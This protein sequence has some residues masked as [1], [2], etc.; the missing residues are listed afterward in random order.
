MLKIFNTLSKKKEVF[1]PINKNQVNIYVCGVTVYDFCHIGHGRTFITF[2]MI[3]RYLKC[4]GFNVK[5]VRNIT[6]IDDKIILKAL[7][8]KTD[9]NIFTDFMI[10]EMHKDFNALKIAI[11]DQEPRVTDYIDNIIN[12]I[13]ELIKNQH[14]YVNKYGDVLF[15]IKNCNDYGILSRQ[16]LHSLA[17]RSHVLSNGIKECSLDF[18][19]W[20]HAKKNEPF[21]NS[22]WGNGRP[23][24]HIECTTMNDIFFNNLIDIHGGGT[25]LLFP[26]H[27]NERAQSICLNNQSIVKY[28]MHIGMIIKNN[29]KM[30]KSLGNIDL[31]RD[32]LKKYDPEVLRYFFLST[33]YR[34]PL[35]YCRN[36]L[37]KSYISLKYLYRSLYNTNPIRNCDEGMDFEIAFYQAM[38]D[39]FNT[40]KVFSVF[41]QIAKK[42][43]F[44]KTKNLLKANKLAFRLQSLGNY[45]GLFLQHPENF[46]KQTSVLHTS[47][48]EKIENLIEKRNMA[49]KLKLWKEAD[50]IRNELVSLNIII[51]DLPDKTIWHKK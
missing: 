42:I 7:Q 46:L 3:I 19:L 34:H 35:Y 24:W 50:D 21:W 49:R 36:Y 29:Y 17:S 37:H 2:D 30:S 13:R 16:S 51:E 32:V 26:H 25:D 20:K 1:K 45:L 41:F 43:N 48:S 12:V 40:P 27:E 38:N 4:I 23:G 28:W 31:L 22:P 47:T 39:D 9:I 18:V 11:P 10:N 5:Y 8:Q 15:S 14:A 44:F 33:H 6:D